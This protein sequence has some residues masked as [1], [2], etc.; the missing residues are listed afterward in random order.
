MPPAPRHAPHAVLLLALAP[1]ALTVPTPGAQA[2]ESDTLLVRLLEEHRSPLSLAEGQLEGPGA[3]ILL[4]EGAAAQFFL[5]G[6]EHGIA[7][8]PE[9]TGALFQALRPHGYRH[10][11]IETS[12]PLAREL[13]RRARS[14]GAEAVLELSRAHP[15][16]VPFFSWTEEAELLARVVEGANAGP[17]LWGVDYEF[18]ATPTFWF[19]WLEERAGSPEGAAHARELAGAEAAAL[20]QLGS[21][22]D[23][24]AFLLARGDAGALAPLRTAFAGDPEATAVLDWMEASMEP[25]GLWF[26]GEP[27]ESNRARTDL[28][29]RAFV[30]HYRSAGDS[31]RVLLKMGGFHLYRGRTPVNVLDVGNLAA[32]LAEYE[33]RTSFH[34]MVL[35]GPG[36]QATALG[37]GGATV[38]PAG[39][40]PWATSLYQATDS[41][42]WTFFDLRPLRPHLDAGRIAPPSEL[43]RL[44]WGY[45]AVLVLVGSGAAG[46]EP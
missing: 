26:A 45:D 37:P 3:D 19:R 18:M 24:T 4:K 46:F 28:I 15:F 11:V 35:A 44:I 5:V 17:V 16:A 2:Q 14:G 9:L 27:W 22:G 21:Q 41:E 7:D 13:E 39:A 29:R 42:R 38:Q 1:L 34:L 6:E 43:A 31:P 33:G 23:P 20:D 40:H 12:P 30:E 8:V 32:M 36:T 25:W 10:L